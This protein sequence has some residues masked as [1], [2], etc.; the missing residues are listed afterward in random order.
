M[1]HPIITDEILKD[2][3]GTHYT[4]IPEICGYFGRACRKINNP[5]GAD[6]PICRSCSLAEYAKIREENNRNE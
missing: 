2:F 1:T 3:E 6:S 5:T 4:W